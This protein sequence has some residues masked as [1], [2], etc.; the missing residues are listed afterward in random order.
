[1]DFITDKELDGL[2]SFDTFYVKNE[3]IL[4]LK[5]EIFKKRAAY[6]LHNN[7]VHELQIGD[8]EFYF[9]YVFRMKLLLRFPNYINT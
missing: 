7:L 4:A 5:S 9:K 1:M 3:K 6:G 8:R 2:F